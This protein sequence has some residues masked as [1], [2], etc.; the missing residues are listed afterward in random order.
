MAKI[1][2]IKAREIL[3]SR[4]LPTIETRIWL[5]DGSWGIA[6]VPSSSSKGKHEAVEVRDEDP[7]RYNG[8]GVLKAVANVNEKIAPELINK[9]AAYQGKID[10]IIIDLDSTENKKN[11]GVNAVLSVSQ[12]VLEA[13]ARSFQMPVYNYLIAKYQ[14][15]QK[16][17]V[18]HLILNMINGGKHGAGNLD[19]QE[20]HIIPSTRMKYNQALQ[21]GSEIYQSLKK[22][23]IEKG[24]IHSVG[25]EGGFAPNLFSNQ[26]ALEITMEAVRKTKYRFAKDLFLGLDVAAGHFYANKKYQIKDRS[27]SLNQEQL[28]EYYQDI[29][30]QYHLF[31]LEDALEP[32]DWYGWSDLTKRLGNNTMIVGD[33]LL[34]TNEQ[35]VKKAIKENA[36][37]A[38][39]VKPNEVGTITETIR[40]IQVCKEHDW[41]IVVSH[42]SGETGDDFIADFAVGIGADYT[43]FGA[44]SRGERISK[45]NRLLKI[46][47]EL[48]KNQNGQK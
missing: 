6:S 37:N 5:E 46:Q 26:D 39:L 27:H 47:Q 20:F 16:P 15:S 40:V 41:K 2:K 14:V 48:E 7:D 3:D 9:D 28:I 44:P 17:K 31:S 12:A 10:Q 19:F 34:C 24:A 36:C 35:R 23:L 21:C 13:S 22:T 11:L 29:N 42:R 43:K 30:E 8:M 4:G 32:E 33:D 45:Y 1:K 38:I 18:P 25:V